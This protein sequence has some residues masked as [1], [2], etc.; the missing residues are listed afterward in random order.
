[1]AS[2]E[3]LLARLDAIAVSLA[4][5]E[6][7]RALLAL[8]SV[9]RELERL[10][11]YSDLDFFVI[12][13]PGYK[14]RFIDNLDWLERVHP[15][16]Y[17]F[18]NSADGYKLMFEDGILCEF[19]VFEEAELTNAIYSPGRIIWRMRVASRASAKRKGP[20]PILT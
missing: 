5:N 7:S 19:A 10:D 17:Q 20:L 12:V 14:V 16:G 13:A 9:G 2:I 8:G 15:V 1:M 18:K 6:H 4:A 11:E 3:T